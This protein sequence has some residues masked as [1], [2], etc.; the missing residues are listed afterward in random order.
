VRLGAL[1]VYCAS[2]YALYV[3]RRMKGRPVSLIAISKDEPDE[4]GLH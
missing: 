4:R 1:F 2:G 3:W